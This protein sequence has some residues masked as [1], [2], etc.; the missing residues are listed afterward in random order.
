MIDSASATNDKI[1]LSQTNA[2]SAAQNRL[3]KIFKKLKKNPKN[4]NAQEN[5]AIFTV[6]DQ[7]DDAVYWGVKNHKEIAGIG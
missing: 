4:K 2:L 1:V 6:E 7:V 5:F 3:Y